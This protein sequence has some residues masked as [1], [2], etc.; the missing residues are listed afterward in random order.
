MM[1][2]ATSVLLI[3]GCGKGQKMTKVNDEQ[4]V[5]AL[6]E[7][8]L[9]YYYK[10]P[11]TQYEQNSLTEEGKVIG[12][13]SSWDMS[14]QVAE[15]DYY[16][17]TVC[18]T[19]VAGVYKTAFNYEFPGTNGGPYMTSGYDGIPSKGVVFLAHGGAGTDYAGNAEKVRALLQ[20]GDIIVAHGGSDG[21]AMLYLGD[22]YGTG[23]NYV[24]HCWGSHATDEMDKVE[25]NGAIKV[26][27]EDELLFGPKVGSNPN[28]QIGAENRAK[29]FLCVYRPFA[30]DEFKNEI[31]QEAVIRMKYA[32]ICIDKYLDITQYNSVTKGQ[33]V[34]LNFRI[35]NNGEKEFTNVPI[36]E[37]KT[38]GLKLVSGTPRNKVNVKA[39]ET[40]LLSYTYEVTANPGEACVFQAGEIAGLPM[41]E[42]SLQ[43]SESKL[44]GAEIAELKK[45]GEAIA[46]G[47]VDYGTELS[48]VNKIYKKVTGKDIGL[49]ETAQE[50]LTATLQRKQPLGLDIKGLIPKEKTAENEKLTAMWP[51]KLYGGRYR[52]ASYEELTDRAWE[53]L[54]EYFDAGD[55]IIKLNGISTTSVSLQSDLTIMVYLGGNDVLMLNKDETTIS[56][57]D[58][59]APYLI[60]ANQILTIR[61]LLVK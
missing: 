10:N 11:Y 4:R 20:P 52:L 12:K 36:N 61:P 44:T 1:L 23:V 38:T 25:K 51:K 60:C 6:R 57:L 35:Q 47:E 21:H 34:V 42:I 2:F 17:Y 59:E 43:V 3:S 30:D 45:L 50:Y 33:Q 31:T 13:R 15:K 41:R 53:F 16:H 40:A 26:Q 19:F 18:S 32:G 55:V 56:H 54:P 22:I 49:P 8:A 7:V 5:Q 48:A 39:G 27:P 58:T 37:C 28:Y 46:A 9:S 29:N 24:I 14:S